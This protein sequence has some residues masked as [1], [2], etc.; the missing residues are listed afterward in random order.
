MSKWN[1]KKRIYNGQILK[2]NEIHYTISDWCEMMWYEV[3]EEEK[4]IA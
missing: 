3:H 2:K 1:S 4:S